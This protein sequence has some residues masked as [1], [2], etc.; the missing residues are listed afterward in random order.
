MNIPVIGR[1]IDE[2]FLTHRLRST[3]LAGITCVLLAFALFL[4][5]LHR[6][7]HQL[8]SLRGRC[9]ERRR[10]VSAMIWHRQRD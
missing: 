2:R 3:S 6:S 9:D 1:F 5:P 10:K 7:P 8:G 4:K